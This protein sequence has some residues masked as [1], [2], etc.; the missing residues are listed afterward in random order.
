MHSAKQ[1]L[2]EAESLPVEGRA[3]VVDSLLQT[4]NPPDTQIDKKWITVA[5]RRLT[6][7]RAE[8]VRPIS[9]EKIFDNVKNRFAT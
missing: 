2:K 7:L 6:E 5:K 1:I 8:Q 4:L 3:A 9:G